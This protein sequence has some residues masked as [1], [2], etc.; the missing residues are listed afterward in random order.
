[1]LGTH[2]AAPHISRQPATVTRAPAGDPDVISAN[3]G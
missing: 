1:V 3:D 2:D